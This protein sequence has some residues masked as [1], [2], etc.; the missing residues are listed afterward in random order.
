MNI[1]QFFMSVILLFVAKNAN[2]QLSMQF[3]AVNEYVFNSKEALNFTAINSSSQS[4]EVL[5]VGSIKK[6]N[7]EVVC[8][9]KTNP[10]WLQTGAN[11][12]TPLTLSLAEIS[13]SN[14]DILEI[15]TK[16]GQYPSGNYVICI[17][18][19]CVNADCNGLGSSAA[20]MEPI[21]TSIQT[22]NPTPLILVNPENESEIEETR[23]LMMWIPPS[24][25]AGS[26]NL[27]YTLILVEML[28]GQNKAD[29][30]NQN[31][32]LIEMEG[33]GNPALLFPSD[34]PELEKGKWYAWQVQAYV[35]KT[36]IAKSEQWKFK[37]KKDS[38][39]LKKVP[40]ELSYIEIKGQSG[41]S[42]FYAVG[43]LKLRHVVRL[44]TGSIQLIIK[45]KN[46]KQMELEQP[47]FTINPGDNRLDM[48]LISNPLFK[49]GQTYTLTGSLLDGEPFLISFIYIDPSLLKNQ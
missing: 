49:H 38:I 46:G 45:D 5:F 27:N 10:V 41:A 22:E 12:F 48:N 19:Q 31:R 26:A 32:P 18:P 25:V 21:C 24:P 14:N 3:N 7:G 39:D 43:Q 30:L 33:I 4:F 16:T 44:T 28:D 35:G 23:P 15:E 42:V 1:R 20:N 17:I 9:F 8:E 13:Y 6:S 47:Q 11:I 34:I 2:A 37:V 36:P 40:K 29:A